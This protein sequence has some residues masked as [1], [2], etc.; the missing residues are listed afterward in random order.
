MAT[1]PINLAVRFLLELSALAVLGIWGWVYGSS[2]S[3]WLGNLLSVSIPI[4]AAVVWGVFN[5]PGDPSRSGKAPVVVP[6]VLRLIIELAF[7]SLATF[8]LY[9]L[10]Y[11]NLSW[12]FGGVVGLHY[13]VS[14]ER[15][16]WLIRR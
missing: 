14:Y 15:M 6:G 16:A 13:L 2:N 12:I 1:H 7:F 8:C 3:P 9:D 11:L 10:M 5:V 4:A